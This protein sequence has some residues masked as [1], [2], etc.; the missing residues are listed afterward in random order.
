MTC[1][2]GPA[3]AAARPGSSA[4]DRRQWASAL[5]QGRDRQWPDNWGSAVIV[6]L[7][8]TAAPLMAAIGIVAFDNSARF[9]SRHSTTSEL[10][11]T[12]HTGGS[13]ETWGV[14]GAALQRSLRNAAAPGP[15]ISDA[16]RHVRAVAQDRVRLAAQAL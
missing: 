7:V 11:R 5:N 13:P 2:S 15:L 6:A 16:Q 8:L 1:A 14:H 12:A 3:S 10:P 4:F 9:A